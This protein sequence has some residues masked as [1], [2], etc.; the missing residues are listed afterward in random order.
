MERRAVLCILAG[1]VF[2]VLIGTVISRDQSHAEKFYS[3]ALRAHDISTDVLVDG[4]TARVHEGVASLSGESTE[5]QSREALR[6]AYARTLAERNPLF[7]FPGTTPSDLTY[8]V[9]VLEA[10]ANQ[11]ADLHKEDGRVGLI[12]TSLYPIEFLRA[13]AA[14]ETARL[15]FIA[16]TDSRHEQEY[17]L[18]VR[19]EI[20]AYVS[21]LRAFRD[22]VSKAI[23]DSTPAYVAAGKIVSKTT[24]LSAIAA[25]KAGLQ[26]SV[27]QFDRRILCLRGH[28]GRCNPEDLSLPTLNVPEPDYIDA[29]YIVRA[30]EVRSFYANMVDDSQIRDAPLIVLSKSTC[31][32]DAPSPPIF[33]VTETTTAQGAPTHNRPL[34]VGD[35]RF[36]RIDEYGDLPFYKDLRSRGMEFVLSPPL[37]HYECMDGAR[38]ANAILSTRAVLSASSSVL[39][40]ADAIRTANENA[41]SGDPAGIAQA[42]A[43]KYNS[44][45][46]DQSLRD[47]A[48]AEQKNLHLL[49]QGLRPDLNITNLFVSRSGFV[50][51]FATHNTSFFEKELALFPASYIPASQ[52][53]YLYD[54]QTPSGAEKRKLRQDVKEYVLLHLRDLEL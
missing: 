35:V 44:M 31:V 43:I 33:V 39:Y 1:I 54:S 34:F 41:L 6:L 30:R 23:P 52:Q 53:P 46:F 32:A 12:R 38:E 25:I 24:I 37:L 8:A 15:E 26:A 18:A 47:I 5:K 45:Q 3:D 50:A 20:T 10:T 40:Q 13:A 42:L 49:R 16:H 9:D 36:I 48:W 21:D 11:L 27:H 4:H 51:L 22:A 19:K 14:A 28:V 17:E 2:L 29:E 7:A